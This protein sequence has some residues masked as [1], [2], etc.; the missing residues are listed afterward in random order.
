MSGKSKYR[1]SIA[2]LDARIAEHREKQRRAPNQEL[3]HYW[4]KEIEKFEREKRKKRERL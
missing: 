1:K 2:S 3:F 4:E